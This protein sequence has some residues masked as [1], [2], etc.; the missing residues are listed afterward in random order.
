VDDQEIDAPRLGTLGRQPDARP[1]AEDRFAGGDLGAEAIETLHAGEKAH[2]EV[3]V[4]GPPSG[5][6]SWGQQGV[7]PMYNEQPAST[8]HY[9]PAA[10]DH[11]RTTV[12]L[13]G[14]LDTKGVE[15]QF[16]R[17]RHRAAGIDTLVM[18]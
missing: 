4:R 11:A 18:D 3:L 13:I 6:I 5:S 14:T 2:V 9:R 8:M 12:L 7:S 15:F 1:A 16:V 10:M 17:E